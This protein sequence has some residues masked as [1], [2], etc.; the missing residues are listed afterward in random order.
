[1]TKCTKCSLHNT[2]R[3]AHPL[4]LGAPAAAAAAT[5]TAATTASLAA[6]AATVAVRFSAVS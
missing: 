4:K 5:A 1:M 6:A 3:I 2:T